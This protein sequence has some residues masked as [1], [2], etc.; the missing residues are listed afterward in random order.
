MLNAAAPR[1]LDKWM[2]FVIPGNFER[3]PFKLGSIE[4]FLDRLLAAEMFLF[5]NGQLGNIS[6]VAVKR[7]SQKGQK[8]GSNR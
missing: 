6:C 2:S 1:L 4:T 5:K 7:G 3:V 8:G